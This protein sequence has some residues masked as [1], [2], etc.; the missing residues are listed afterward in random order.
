MA[1][2]STYPDGGEIQA[3]DQFVIARGGLNKSILGGKITNRT[4]FT[5]VIKGSTAVGAGT[6]TLQDG[7]YSRIGNL[8]F[9][10]VGLVWTAHTGTGT[11]YVDGLPIASYGGDP[12]LYIPCTVVWSNVTLAAGAKILAQVAPGSTTVAL[13]SVDN[14]AIALLNIDAAATINLSGFYF[15][16]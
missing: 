1:K 4:T 10:S 13:Y 11:M 6:Y 12:S 3:G 16:A 5:P 9:F 7:H 8:V 2:I 15:V 14:G